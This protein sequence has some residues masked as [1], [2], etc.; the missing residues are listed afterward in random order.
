M[1]FDPSTATE[2]DPSSAVEYPQRPTFDQSSASP[3]ASSLP[4]EALGAV[5]EPWLKMG[6][7]VVAKPIADIAG[8]GGIVAHAFGGTKY[9]P[10]QLRKDVESALTYAPR[11]AAGASP[12]NPLNAIPEAIG[13]VIDEAT[14]AIATGITDNEIAQA[15]IKE[16]L[17]QGVGLLGVKK[18]PVVAKKSIQYLDDTP[19]RL[20]AKAAAASVADW[21]RAKPIEAAKV[22]RA[23]DI[24]LPPMEVNPTKANRARSVAAGGNEAFRTASSIAN[25]NKWN[26]MARKNLGLGPD[27][28]LDAAGYDLARKQIAVPYDKAAE[29]GRLAPDAN[30]IKNILDIEVPDIL[31][32]GEQSMGR[33]QR[34]TDKVVQD[35]QGGMTGNDAL[36][37]ARS[38]RKEA[39]TVFDAARAGQVDP[40]KIA[41]AKAKFAIAEEL[42]SLIS[43][44]IPDPKWKSQFDTSRKKMAESYALE[45]ATNLATSQIDPMVF[46][47]EMSGRHRLTGAA[48][49]MGEIAANYPGIADIYA[50]SGM[51]VRMPSRSGPAGTAGYALGAPVGNAV[52]MSALGATT[53]AVMEG[54]YGKRLM[55][56]QAQKRLTT[57]VDRRR[58]LV[59]NGLLTGNKP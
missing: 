26:D 34:L 51:K 15:G 6:T 59:N 19:K 30:V 8:L 21:Q 2:F 39:K 23:N 32:A 57:P 7:A 17:T 20:E 4:M 13:G 42:D 40:I 56:P 3:V 43:S 25:K 9:D 38:L 41:E 49:D 33:V 54:L 24:I 1:P 55:T 47:Q 48:K 5:T 14:G 28:P 22:A 29:I 58:P 18:A 45:R 31:P 37:S 50:E 35:I 46:A 36:K 16:A 52:A 12:Y 53:A 10:T 11:T 44:N 27:R